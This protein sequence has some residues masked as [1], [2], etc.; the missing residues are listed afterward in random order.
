MVYDQIEVLRLQMQQ[1]AL[2]KDLSDPKVVN[3]SEKLDLLINEFYFG[4]ERIKG[5]LGTRQKN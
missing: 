1:I 3:I 5:R 2:D 4:Q